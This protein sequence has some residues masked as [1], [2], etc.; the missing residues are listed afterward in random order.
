MRSIAA[1]FLLPVAALAIAFTIL[2]V[3]TTHSTTRKDLTELTNR[4]GALALEFDL[5]IRDYV[6]REIRPLMQER[7]G[8]DEFIPEAMSTSF[9]ARRIFEAV[10][11]K[12]PDY[13]LKFSSDNPRNPVN[14]AGVDELRMLD[15]FRNNP[16]AER[17]EG[18]IRLNGR[19]YLAH[20]SPRRMTESCRQCHGQPADAPTPLVARYGDTAGFQQR[21]GDVIALDTIAIPM[22]EVNAALFSAAAKRSVIMLLGIASFFAAIVVLFRFTV[23]RR[24]AAIAG[25]FERLTEAPEDARV[26]PLEVRGRDEISALAA[27]FNALASKMCATHLSLEQR[28]GERTVELALANEELQREVMER[29]QAEEALRESREMLKLVLDNIPQFVFWKDAS[30]K[31]AGCNRNFAQA[32]GLSDPTD[33]VGKTDYDLPWGNELADRYRADDRRVI[34]TGRPLPD[35]VE[36][37]QTQNGETRWVSTNK[38]PFCNGSGQIVGVLG[39]FAD[40]TERKQAEEALRESEQRFRTV[41]DDVGDAIFV[42]NLDGRFIEANREAC[43]R[44][45]YSRDEFLQM[46]PAD[47]DTPDEAIRVRDR[48]EQLRHEG[49]IIFETTHARRDGL[50]IP[51]EI[52]AWLIEF[53]GKPAALAV[54]R[55]VTERKQAEEALRSSEQRLRTVVNANKDAIVAVGEDGLVTLF[56]PAAERMFGRS[57]EEMLGQRLD[58]LMPPEYRERH[59]KYVEGYFARG[60]PNGAIGRTVEL[61]AVRNDGRRFPVELSLSAGQLGKQRFALAVIRDVTERKQTEEAIRENANAL[62]AANLELEAQKHQLQAQRT[63]LETINRAL[64]EAKDRAEAA[65]R[66]KSEFLANMSHEI[67]TPMTAI[68]GFADN[69]LDPQLSES[70]RLDAIH[71]IR[72]NGEHL[73][74]ILNDILDLSKIEAG[75]MLVESVPCA[76]HQVIA[77]VAS[78]AHVR[79]GAKGLRLDVEYEGPIPTTIRTDP[80]RLRQI[81]Y[82]LIGNAIKFTERG[83]VRLVTRLIH[84]DPA[85]P[86]QASKPL[87][88]FDVRD[89]GIGM[90]PMQ[91]A[92]L[93]Q[94]F[95]QKDSSTTRKFGGT[96]LGLT[97]SQRLANLLG[98]EITVESEPGQ[99]STFRVTVATGPLGGV[100][101]VED[102]LSLAVAEHDQLRTEGSFEPLQPLACRILLAE[103]GQDNQRLIRHVLRKAG[104]RVAAVENGNAAVEAALRARDEGQPFDVILMDMQMPVMDGY[105]ATSRLRAQGYSGTIIALTA[106]AM[107]T[108]RDKCL[109][110]GCNDYATKPIER[111]ALIETIQQHLGAD[112]GAAEENTV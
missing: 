12:H 68:L 24:V 71:T 58:C 69:L 26:T 88:Q 33:I 62:K 108:D 11:E 23:A 59:Q 61:P 56:N 41:F 39:T 85:E 5:A 64:D 28:V 6:A 98:G 84:T 57:A 1:K 4:Q 30:G 102:P 81:L 29:K 78:L 31:Y 96:G 99:G 36:P 104:A 19:T 13:V 16:T 54:A 40:I 21:V 47:I 65:N 90:A 43:E 51:V 46:T 97:I 55:D 7:V 94:P 73:L 32:V 66:A 103:D 110:A 49:H 82:N 18:E 72:R 74:G 87:L 63:D 67:R 109:T 91:I 106:H 10:Q 35:I 83:G 27:S 15:Y 86:S 17:W 107:A 112:A 101:M 45:G 14:Q 79:A 8:P 100:E 92:G 37:W 52:N 50:A 76:P 42:F 111:K 9:V 48:L 34:E 25:H 53:D 93:F 105:E 89:T 80:T 22:D 95:T 38:V 20:F 70:G 77:D 2:D 60:E 44:L 3:Y 75:K